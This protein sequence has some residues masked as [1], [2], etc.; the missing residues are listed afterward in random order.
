MDDISIIN[1]LP[2]NINYLYPF[3]YFYM[4]I[5]QCITV[6]CVYVS[7]ITYTINSKFNPT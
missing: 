6:I 4:S 1:S 2:S 3:L 7:F 5:D